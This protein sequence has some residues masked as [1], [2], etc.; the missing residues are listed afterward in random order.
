MMNVE[1]IKLLEDY[2]GADSHMTESTRLYYDLNLY[3]DDAVEF[4]DRFMVRF[5]VDMS[6]FRFADYF[7]S[8]GDWILPSILRFLM[9]K[10]QPTYRS[11]TLSDLQ[12]AIDSRSL[13]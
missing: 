6:E 8:E 1:L 10:S 4:L 12:L 5:S 9:G 13:K 7:P 3:G 11:L 2:C